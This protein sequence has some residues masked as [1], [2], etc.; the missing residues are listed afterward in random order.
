MK[1]VQVSDLGVFPI[2]SDN[3]TN[4]N[5][6]LLLCPN[7]IFY[8][9]FQVEIYILF[10]YI[11]LWNQVSLDGELL[12]HPRCCSVWL[13]LNDPWFWVLGGFVKDLLYTIGKL[14]YRSVILEII[15]NYLSW[16]P[17]MLEKT[18]WVLALGIFF[19]MESGCFF[20]PFSLE[21]IQVHLLGSLLLLELCDYS[22][23]FHCSR[24][25]I[26]SAN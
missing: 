12:C 20:S 3:F 25:H 26:D 22:G 10:K 8:F 23:N 4:V 11:F 5:Q 1:A 19:A 13:Q 15:E 24:A 9:F 7:F 21:G 17:R 14:L 18:R 2:V 16:Y 6:K